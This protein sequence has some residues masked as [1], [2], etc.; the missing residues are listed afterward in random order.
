MLLALMQDPV[1]AV[2][3]GLLLSMHAVARGVCE[4]AEEGGEQTW[5]AAAHIDR[6]RCGYCRTG[7]V[8]T[9]CP[10]SPW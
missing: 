5:C 10:S 1:H 6:S 4:E 8:S 7:A 2:H 9:L 3:T